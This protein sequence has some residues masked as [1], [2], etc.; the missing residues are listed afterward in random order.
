MNYTERSVMD[1][2]SGNVTTLTGGFQCCL[3]IAESN[4]WHEYMV[5]G[6]GYDLWNRYCEAGA[7]KDAQSLMLKSGDYHSYSQLLSASEAKREIEN[8]LFHFAEKWYND[9]VLPARKAK[10]EPDRRV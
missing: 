9:V 6:D 5:F 3:S 10:T 8:E 7:I 1:R 4:A 2:I